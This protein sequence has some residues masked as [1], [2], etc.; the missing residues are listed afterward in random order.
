MRTIGYDGRGNTASELRPGSV[1]TA[2]T[3]DGYARLTGYSRSDAGTYAFTWNGLDDRV[4][5]DLPSGAGRA[6]SGKRAALKAI[7]QFCGTEA[8]A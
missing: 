2:T 1:T 4:M 5:M 6:S 7:V 3:Y 8:P